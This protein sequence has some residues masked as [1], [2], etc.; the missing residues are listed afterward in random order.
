MEP[1]SLSGTT[2]DDAQV[3]HLTM[4]VYVHKSLCNTNLSS[5]CRKKNDRHED[6]RN[7]AALVAGRGPPRCSII[8]ARRQD[9]H[10]SR[11]GRYGFGGGVLLFILRSNLG[12]VG[13]EGLRGGGRRGWCEEWARIG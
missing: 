5:I 4:L 7:R 1:I 10:S 6:S 12:R 11:R 8:L 2:S 9:S 13:P 3:P